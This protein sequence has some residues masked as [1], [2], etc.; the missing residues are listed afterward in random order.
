MK[1]YLLTF[2]I[3]ITFQGVAL[4]N[5]PA[6][7]SENY[8]AGLYFKIHTPVGPS[9]GTV[10]L[11]HGVLEHSGRYQ[12][13][14][15]LLNQQNFTVYSYDLRGHGLS[16]GVRGHIRKFQSYVDDLERMVN[17][18]KAEQVDGQQ[19]LFL[20]GHSM[21]GLITFLYINQ[22]KDQAII[23]GVALSAPALHLPLKTLDK[24]KLTF[25]K[26]LTKIIPK[27]AAG[28]PIRREDLTNDLQMLK[29]HREDQL[30]VPDLTISLGLELS[31]GA[32]KAQ[33]YLKEEKTL[34]PLFIIQGENDVIVDATKNIH[35]ATELVGSENLMI[36]SEGLHENLNSK[37]EVR[38]KIMERIGAFYKAQL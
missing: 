1:K 3:F 7:F 33:A 26:G 36:I 20:F 31:R 37:P 32:K 24:V 11:T 35:A 16:Y 12:H 19:P 4:S 15:E 13:F 10:L 23:D 6:M 27:M 17:L 28:V 21:G 38:K 34:P 18:I 9:Q 14:I 8:H 29:K 22:L 2:L 30:I 25:A 5:T